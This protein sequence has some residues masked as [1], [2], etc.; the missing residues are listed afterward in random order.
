MYGAVQKKE[1]CANMPILAKDR[2]NCYLCKRSVRHDADRLRDGNRY[3]HEACEEKH[4]AKLDE[5][6]VMS[7]RRKDARIARRKSRNS[8]VQK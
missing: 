8:K 6:K 2:I 1:C 4:Y 5:R 7:E 3:I